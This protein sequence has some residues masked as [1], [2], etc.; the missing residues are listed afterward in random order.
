ML[1]RPSTPPRDWAL[2]TRGATVSAATTVNVD[3]LTVLEKSG[4]VADQVSLFWNDPV[5]SP[6]PN[7]PMSTI[8]I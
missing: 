5:K 2:A 7:S 8:S 3:Y 6:P 1:K 4:R